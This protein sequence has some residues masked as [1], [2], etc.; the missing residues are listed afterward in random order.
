MNI[1]EDLFGGQQQQQEL[2]NFAKRYDQ[3]HPSQG[4]DDQEVVQKHNQVAKHLSPQQYQQAAKESFEKLTPQ[5][6]QE[7]AQWLKQRAKQH[8]AKVPEF[9]QNQAQSPDFLAS[10]MGNMQQQGGTGAL[11]GSLMGGGSGGSGNSSMLGNPV[12]KAALAGIA[13]MAAKK[14]LG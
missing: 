14:F 7:F 13:A 12:A 6:R 3:G 5:E 9:D 4:Y 2:Q 8:N 10:L 11:L 1:V